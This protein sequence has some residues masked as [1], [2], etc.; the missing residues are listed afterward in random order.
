MRGKCSSSQKRQETDGMWRATLAQ[1]Q[2]NVGETFEML[3]TLHKTHIYNNRPRLQRDIDDQSEY[4]AKTAPSLFL[5]PRS[6]PISVSYSGWARHSMNA[7][8]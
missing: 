5:L 3:Q 6:Y 2:V 7:G 8:A 1:W 4:I